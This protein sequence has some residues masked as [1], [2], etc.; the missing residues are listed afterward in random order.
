MGIGDRV[1][2]TGRVTATDRDALLAGASALVFPS[3][4]EGFGAPLVEAMALGVPVVCS[5]APAV[6]EVVADAAVI[7]DGGAEA[8][9]AAVADAA[10]RRDELVARGE[11]RRQA[12]TLDA[13][14]AALAAAYRLA[15]GSS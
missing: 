4:Y 13:S 8:W 15:A 10:S 9:A 7:V 12:F 5:A 3:E 2:R 1:I 14:S 11:V 6:R